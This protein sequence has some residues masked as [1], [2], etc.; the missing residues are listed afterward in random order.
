MQ[1]NQ[2][3]DIDL[4]KR[5]AATLRDLA[6][7]TALIAQR[8]LEICCEPQ[9]L[10]IAETGAD[11]R[12]HL[13]VPAAEQAWRDLSST[14]AADGVTLHIVSAFRSIERQAEIVRRKLEEGLSL[15]AVLSVSAPPGYSEHHTGRAVDVG[16]ESCPALEVEFENTEAF[17]W[18][19]AHA[20]RFGFTLSFPRGNRQGY[21]YEPWH[22]C[23]HG[24]EV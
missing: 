12:E 19:S 17:Q 13:L 2:A 11:G 16:E 14:A 4:R 21:A 7:P 9:E 6:I 23:F 20:G 18:L 5:V 22:W 24:T 8:G 15:E 3:I 10:V 1:A